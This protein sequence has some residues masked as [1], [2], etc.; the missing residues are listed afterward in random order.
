M[1]I[2]RPFDRREAFEIFLANLDNFSEEYKAIDFAIA[3]AQRFQAGIEAT[4]GVE[5]VSFPDVQ[6]ISSYCRF[7]AKGCE[8]RIEL[9]DGGTVLH[10]VYATPNQAMGMAIALNSFTKVKEAK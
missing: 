1:N 9:S 8:L 2:S 6:P 3:C 10:A 7:Y 5:R 4:G